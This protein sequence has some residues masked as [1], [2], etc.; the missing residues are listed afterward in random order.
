MEA[1]HHLQELLT[2]IFQFTFWLFIYLCLSFLSGVFHVRSKCGVRLGAPPAEQREWRPLEVGAVQL[3]GPV[4]RTVP[5][6][7]LWALA[8]RSLARRGAS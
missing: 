1:A 4:Y 7:D 5:R 2:E 8:P 6:T 3:P